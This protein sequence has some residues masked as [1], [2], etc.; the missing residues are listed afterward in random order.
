MS[1]WGLWTRFI[2]VRLSPLPGFCEMSN[3][4][5]GYILIFLY[6]HSSYTVLLRCRGFHLSL[7]LYT[8]GRTPWTSVR[9]VARPLPTHRTTQTQNKR[10]HT[11][12]TSMPRVAFESMITD[13]E[14][15]K[16]VHALDRS[17]TVTGRVI[18]NVQK[19]FTTWACAS[20]LRMT[21]PHEFLRCIDER[22]TP[23]FVP[24]L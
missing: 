20:F 3:E 21:L 9:P 6:I 1:R 16:T 2:L 13:S 18:Y 4:L 7:G 17:A 10:I 19:F 11:H 24:P 14:R 23:C 12:Q 22:H 15:T 5:S 8:I